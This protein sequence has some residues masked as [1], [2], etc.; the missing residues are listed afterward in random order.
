[1]AFSVKIFQRT[2]EF[3]FRRCIFKAGYPT[4]ISRR[5]RKKLLLVLIGVL[6]LLSMLAFNRSLLC[7]ETALLKVLKALAYIFSLKLLH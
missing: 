3:V 6:A 2:E 4:Q 5:I 7:R 1:M